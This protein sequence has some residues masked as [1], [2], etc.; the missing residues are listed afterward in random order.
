MAMTQQDSLQKIKAAHPVDADLFGDMGAVAAHLCDDLSNSFVGR[1]FEFM[2][3]GKYQAIAHSGQ[4]SEVNRIYWREM[5]FRIYWAAALNLARHQ[6]WQAACVRAY[7]TP[8]NLLSFAASLRGLLEG[9]Q[10]AWYS[11]NPVPLALGQNKSLIESALSG[12]M[13]DKASA[14]PELEDRL[15][16]FVYGR[17]IAKPERDLAPE[18]H[19]AMDPKDYRDA[20]SPPIRGE[21]KKLYDELCGICHPTAF[22]LTFLWEGEGGLVR[23]KAREDESHIRR[24]CD[25]YR[26]AI[27]YALRLSVTMS[28]LCLKALNWFSLAQTRCAE[29]ERWNFDDVPAWRKAE[30]AAL[31]S[32][33]N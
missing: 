18:S 20:I 28:A 31:G 9:A 26:E 17:K 32:L 24:L 6:R 8:A 3:M 19:I 29:I 12:T 22:S 14:S 16:H 27:A 2:E 11:L 5:L 33:V 13:N 25:Q 21:F 4:L 10:D 15:I 23:I 1:Q 30:A 7:T